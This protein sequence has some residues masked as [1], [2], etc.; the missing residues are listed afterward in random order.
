M[1]VFAGRERGGA[2]WEVLGRRLSLLQRWATKVG[3]VAGEIVKRDWATEKVVEMKRTLALNKN[4]LKGRTRP[5][6]LQ[7][8]HTPGGPRSSAPLRR[9]VCPFKG[10]KPRG[11]ILE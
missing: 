6:S 5:C 7:G 1:E 10:K 4:L 8:E 2:R 11:R 9:V 3:R